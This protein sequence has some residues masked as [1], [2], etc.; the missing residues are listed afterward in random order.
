MLDLLHKSHGDVF[1]SAT[2]SIDCL[3]SQARNDLL[4]PEKLSLINIGSM[5]LSLADIKEY[6]N[7]RSKKQESSN[8]RGI[9]SSQIISSN[10][11]KSH[12][13]YY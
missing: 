5:K 13:I 9:I 6:S 4:C 8:R 3:R 10:E 7:N 11:R 2:N 12:V 1:K